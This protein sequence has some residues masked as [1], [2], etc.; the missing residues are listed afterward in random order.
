MPDC[1]HG[2]HLGSNYGNPTKSVEVNDFI[3]KLEARKQ[4][5]DCLKNL[6]TDARNSFDAYTRFS[7]CRCYMQM[8]VV[9]NTKT[10]PVLLSSGSMVCQL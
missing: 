6:T 4:G 5:A 1:L 9:I 10:Q 3:K 8:I 2:W 7:S